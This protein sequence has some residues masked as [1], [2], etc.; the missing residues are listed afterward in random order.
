MGR[1]RRRREVPSGRGQALRFDE[2]GR[3]PL[4]LS[5]QIKRVSAPAAH[6]Y[7]WVTNTFL[8][9]GLELAKA[10]GFE[11]KTVITWAKDRFGI[12]QYFRG[13]TEPCIFAVRGVLPYK[14][15]D[16]KRQQGTTLL[17]APRQKHSAKPR[18][19]RAMIE[20]VS[21]A[22]RLELFG[23]SNVP[24]DWDTSF[25]FDRSSVIFLIYIKAQF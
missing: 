15:E 16:G 13:Q 5:S 19:M 14:V 2:A 18:E 1:D 25:T 24:L 8:E 10:W 20:K 23:R 6:L 7:L 12:G 4:S 9:D 3:P 21:Y 22:P 17:S 11:Y